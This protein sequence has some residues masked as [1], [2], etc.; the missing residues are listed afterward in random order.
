MAKINP[1]IIVGIVAVLAIVG[2]AGFMLLPSG[3]SSVE[4]INQVPVEQ[5]QAQVEKPGEP[6]DVQPKP[7]KPAEPGAAPAPA[8]APIRV[9][10]P[11]PLAPG[12]HAAAEELRQRIQDFFLA[13]EAKDVPS[14]NT[15]YSKDQTYAEWS[16]V[17]GVFKGQYNGYSNV[18]ILMATVV[19]NTDDIDILIN[20]YQVTFDGDVAT[21][22]Y[23]IVNVGSGKMIGQFVMD[24]SI[25]SKWQYIDGE[26]LMID[27]RWYFELFCVEL[28]AEGTVFPLS[29][30]QKSDLDAANNLWNAK[31]ADKVNSIGFLMPFGLDD[32]RDVNVSEHPVCNIERELMAPD[33]EAADEGRAGAAAQGRGM[34]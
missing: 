15:F 23:Q 32:E 33:E 7:A 17:A 24:V 16:G 29:W 25:D 19:G 4:P 14:L 22:S 12:E 21:T 26:W 31:W 20:G 34:D 5:P 2:V 13:F 27:D 11:A 9:A 10:D 30:R 18:R 3:P 1:I 28:I 8:P 6:A